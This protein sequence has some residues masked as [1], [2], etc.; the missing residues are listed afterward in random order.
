MN[1]LEYIN[2][3]K[4]ELKKNFY[5]RTSFEKADERYYH[6]LGVAKM[7]KTLALIYR[8][9][10]DEFSNKCEIAGILHDYGKFFRRE[11]YEDLTKEYNVKFN[12]DD[13]SRNVYHGYYGYLAIKRDLNINDE[14][15]LLAVRNHIM[16]AKE[17]SLI[18]EIIY[19]SDFIEEGRS[20]KEIPILIPLR[21]LALNGKLKE[22]V[23]LESK[24][25]IKYL[26]SKN[27]V[28][29]PISLECYNGYNKYLKDD[30]GE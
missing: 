10:D 17:M 1:H 9:N 3:L 29:N 5:S 24:F 4:E 13:A 16:G 28:I 19:V 25:V 12:Y 6:S 11:E 26:I 18:E 7:A 2:Y 8:P 20:E 21:D 23:A 15:I 22:A 14:E 30:K 27:A